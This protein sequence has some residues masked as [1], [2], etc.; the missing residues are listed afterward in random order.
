MN[1][2]IHDLIDVHVQLVMRVLRA[3]PAA[4]GFGEPDVDPAALRCV[5][6]RQAEVLMRAG[7]AASE[8]I[9]SADGECE[10][11]WCAQVVPCSVMRR[12]PT[13]C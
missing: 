9:V 4:S 6:R 8:L 11:W 1:A 12:T 5:L 13:V 7:Y 10:Q 2:T 3:N